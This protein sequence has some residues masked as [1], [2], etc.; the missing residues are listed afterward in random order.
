MTDS[1]EPKAQ[2]DEDELLSEFS[3]ELE[4]AEAGEDT[5]PARD[6]G[7]DLDALDAFLDEFGQ[8][9]AP[10]TEQ[11][12]MADEQDEPGRGAEI[13]ADEATESTGE[14]PDWD[15]GDD[16]DENIPELNVSAHVDEPGFDSLEDM[17]PLEP[18]LSARATHS[19]NQFAASPTYNHN[20]TAAPVSIMADEDDAAMEKNKTLD[21]S[22]IGVALLALV[23]AAVAGWFAISLHGQLTDM[24]TVLN[25]QRQEQVPVVSLP[26]RQTQEALAMLGQRVDELTGMLDKSVDEAATLDLNEFAA[27]QKST[28][29][30]LDDLEQRL[31]GM[32]DEL[33]QM[34]KKLQAAV[35]VKAA[36]NPK[37]APVA[38]PAA[39]PKPAPVAAPAPAASKPVVAPKPVIKPATQ[40]IGWVVNVASLTDAKAAEAERQRML[41]EGFKVEVQTTEMSGRTWHRV[42]ATGFTSR[43]QAQVYS[44]MIRHKM[45]VTP[46]VGLSD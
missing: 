2:H 19:D 15:I 41:K 26:D 31:K 37:P 34:N 7:T 4:E 6:L 18:T 32:R 16:D 39:E 9:A 23:I 14:R 8:E 10:P 22:T 17:A 46:W 24:R 3:A 38:K 40:S 20:A 42:R 28:T 29:L 1:E 5:Q 43:E 27:Q 30:R 36:P 12:T 11:Q 25:M 13:P 33:A 44:D 45:N 21:I 35:A